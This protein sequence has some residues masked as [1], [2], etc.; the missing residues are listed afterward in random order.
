[1]R[2][3]GRVPCMSAANGNSRRNHRVNGQRDSGTW[4]RE[5]REARGWARR[6]M[7]RRL[8]QAGHD[9]GDTTM[10]SIDSL[11][12]YIRRWEHGHGL[13]ERYKLH[14]CTALAIGLAASSA[15]DTRLTSSRMTPRSPPGRGKKP[16]ALDVPL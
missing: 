10:P 9:T 11:C 14:Y 4:L 5:Q 8:I 1:M 6:D 13:T 2:G 15:S 12:T 3:H 7:A 16:A